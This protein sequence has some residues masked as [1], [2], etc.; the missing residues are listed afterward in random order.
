MDAGLLTALLAA[1]LFAATDVDDLFLL[2]AFFADPRARAG[3]VVAGQ[4]LGIGGLVAA[5]LVLALMTLAVPTAYVGLLGLIPI[6]MGLA[7]LRALRADVDD[8]DEKPPAGPWRGA[9]TVA[10]VTLANGGDNLGVYT[11]VFAVRPGAEIAAIIV[12]FAVVTGVWCALAHALVRHP[13]LGPPIRRHAL[14]LT[15]LVLVAVG[16]FV[17]YDADTLSLLR[18]G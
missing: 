2:I 13:A 17:L 4:F 10:A 5:S 8:D 6:A 18:Q 11:P 3:E 7:R 1:A 15:P 9:L 14:W 16:V 12:V